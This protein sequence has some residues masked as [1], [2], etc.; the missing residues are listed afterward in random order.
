MLRA[1]FDG[2]I[3]AESIPIGANLA[4]DPSVD[5]ATARIEVRARLGVATGTTVLA[6]FGFVHPVKG[7]RYL[8]E[9]LAALRAEGRALHLLV[10]GGFESLALPAGEA[11]AFEAELRYRIAAAGAAGDVTITGF[12]PAAQVTRMLFA[13][14]I[15]VLPFTAGVTTKSGS[16]LTVL[17]HG[18]P[19]VVTAAPQ[20]DPDLVDGVTCVVV[21]AVRD[22]PAIVAGLRRL[23]DAGLRAR[24]A[25]RGRAVADARGW[26]S[27][28]ERHLRLYHGVPR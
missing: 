7:L 16:L 10:L 3:R 14:D 6:F 2:R 24:I 23:D 27:I 20:A 8:I 18:L 28:A 25:D 12:L 5:R 1:R 15:A 21:P 19:T 22:A 13:A 26:Q 11:R 4:V 9:A 17:A